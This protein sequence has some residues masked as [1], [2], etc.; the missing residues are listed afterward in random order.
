MQIYS[1]TMLRA[2]AIVFVVYSHAAALG[3]LTIDTLPERV[4]WNIVS[5]ATTMFVFISGFLF[6]HAFVKRFEF[7][8]FITKKIKHL[9]VPY[10]VLSCVALAIG[11][12]DIAMENFE[13]EFGMVQMGA[14]MLGSGHAT[15]AYWFIPFALMLFA[16]SP[17]HM[18]FVTLS[19]R[20]QLIIVGVLFAIALLIHR[21]LY[22][23]G[24]AQNL[25]YYTP[26]YLLGMMCSQHR[27]MA[28]PLL[29]RL[30]WPLLGA[31]LGLAVLQATLGASGNYFKPML[32]FGGIDL[33]L[34]HT[35]CLCLFLMGFLRRFEN[36]RSK[37]IDVLA[38]TSF[39]VFFLHPIVLELLLQSPWL[40]VDA[41]QESWAR[42]T[43]LSGLCVAICTAVAWYARRVFGP[44]SRYV[45]GY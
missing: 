5:G 18:K 10:I 14:Y 34:L 27:A 28:E 4:V 36:R 7:L 17:L 2:V 8:P 45:T 21:P 40:Q 19:L 35:I 26:T 6:H 37:T 25:L 43:V 39:A 12:S 44:Q 30:T 1:L 31:T 23:L 33:M 13:G 42:F 24:A 32:E 38:D 20:T 3:A 16:M 29:A 22:N 9:L 41:G 11:C 15:V